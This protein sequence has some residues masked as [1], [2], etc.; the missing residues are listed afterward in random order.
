MYPHRHEE[1]SKLR[2][3][4]ADLCPLF[5]GFDKSSVEHEVKDRVHGDEVAYTELIIIIY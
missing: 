3:I 2:R 5:I 4:E 1:R